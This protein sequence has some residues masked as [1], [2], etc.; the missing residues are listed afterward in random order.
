MLTCQQILLRIKILLGYR[1]VVLKRRRLAIYVGATTLVDAKASNCHRCLDHVPVRSHGREMWGI[2]RR[3]NDQCMALIVALVALERGFLLLHNK[4][5][6]ILWTVSK[7]RKLHATDFFV[8]HN[9]NQNL[10]LEKSAF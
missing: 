7:I 5:S 1:R 4:K 8:W 3:T 6:Y 9:Q 2:R 10:L